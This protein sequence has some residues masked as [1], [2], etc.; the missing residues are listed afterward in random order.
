MPQSSTRR[1]ARR[2]S[3]GE[4]VFADD[5]G[6]L[7]SASHAQGAGDGAVVFSCIS[8]ARQSVRAIQ[9][10]SGFVLAEVD[11]EQLRTWLREAPKIGRLT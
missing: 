9:V 3:G 1:P 6:L 2:K 5:A 10:D 7:W 11:D 4:R 8:D